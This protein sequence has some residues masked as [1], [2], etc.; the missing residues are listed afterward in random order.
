MPSERAWQLTMIP[1]YLALIPR[2]EK[3]T[4]IELD[5]TK[6][7]L[8]AAPG[9]LYTELRIIPMET[10]LPR[11]INWKNFNLAEESHFKSGHLLTGTL[12][13][14]PILRSPFA[15]WKGM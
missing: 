8:V 2:R 14:V 12:F 7:Y 5:L 11:E 3:L 10:L 4:G 6:H 9:D 13:S 1:S 15:C